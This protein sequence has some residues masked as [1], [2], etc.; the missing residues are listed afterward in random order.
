M[1]QGA[2]AIMQAMNACAPVCDIRG[3]AGTHAGGMLERVRKVMASLSG[4]DMNSV[5]IQDLLA[6]DT[7][8]PRKVGA[9]LPG[10]IQWKT[11][12]A[13]RRW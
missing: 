13:L 9:V 6:V 7:F 4:H 10:N 2:Q 3:E 8:I 1:A 12:L 5:H 11:R